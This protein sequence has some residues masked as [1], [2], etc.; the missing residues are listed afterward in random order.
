MKKVKKMNWFSDFSNNHVK[1]ELKNLKT[2]VNELRIGNI[3]S[4]DDNTGIFKV[5]GINLSEEGYLINTE[6][7]KNEVW[8]NNVDLI[9]KVP[10]TKKWL[11]KMGF[12]YYEEE[13][14][15]FHSEEKLLAVDLNTE[16]F[17]YCGSYNFQ[18]VQYV[19]Q[20]QNIYFALE[21]EE[22]QFDF[23][24]EKSLKELLEQNQEEKQKEK[25]IVNIRLNQGKG[26]VGSTI[27]VNY[28]NGWEKIEINIEE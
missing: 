15:Y 13:A 11:F 20:L 14:M 9:K 28:G 12:E 4:H 18:L 2:K 10:L 7:A 5:I 19:H 24:K 23:H 21:N 25:Q 6:S 22:I 17:W 8:L 1:E 27:Q 26:G 16:E 3:V